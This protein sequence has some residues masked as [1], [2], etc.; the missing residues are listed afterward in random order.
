MPDIDE[1]ESLITDM[2]GI[3]NSW[4]GRLFARLVRHVRLVTRAV[5]RHEDRI[6]VLEQ[7]A[8]IT[9]PPQQ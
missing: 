7:R 8:G 4:T 5:Q 1:A 9:P 6:A 2:H 3:E